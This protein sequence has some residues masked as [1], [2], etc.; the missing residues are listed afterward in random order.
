M[1]TE[2]LKAII[3]LSE[4]NLVMND[5]QLEAIQLASCINNKGRGITGVLFH[6]ANLFFQYLEGTP[7]QVDS[8]LC[9]ITRDARHRNISL[10]FEEAIEERIFPDWS[11]AFFKPATS[12]LL[13]LCSNKWWATNGG[14]IY[15]KNRSSKGLEMLKG[16]CVKCQNKT[17]EQS[18]I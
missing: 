12:E 16:I 11:M 15:S 1:A 9:S 3:Y 17:L 7:A 2:N 14:S 6:I 4:E 8:L 10:L 18:L 5:R 13:S